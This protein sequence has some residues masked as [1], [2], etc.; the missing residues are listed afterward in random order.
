MTND[1]MTGNYRIA[2]ITLYNDTSNKPHRC[3]LY[4]N[5]ISVGDFCVVAASCYT[6]LVA[7]VISIEEKTEEKLTEEIICKADFTQYLARVHKREKQAKLLSEMKKR[8]A[9]LQELTRY[10]TLAK[11]DPA[12]ATLLSEFKDLYKED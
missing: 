2:T 4:D 1:I 8:S 10:E 5:N 12:M 6:I 9:E 7:Q 11:A 3:A